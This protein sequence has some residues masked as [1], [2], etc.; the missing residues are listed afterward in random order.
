MISLSSRKRKLPRQIYHKT[1]EGQRFQLLTFVKNSVIL[2]KGLS[3]NQ[4]M[5]K[6]IKKTLAKHYKYPLKNEKKR[7]KIWRNTL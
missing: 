1:I 2:I 4:C 5:F 3:F 7:G 6:S